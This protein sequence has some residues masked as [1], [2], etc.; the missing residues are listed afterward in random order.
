P[1]SVF[2]PASPSWAALSDLASSV[3]SHPHRRSGRRLSGVETVVLRQL[4]FAVVQPEKN[5]KPIRL[6]NFARLTWTRQTGTRNGLQTRAFAILATE[7]RA[8]SDASPNAR[9]TYPYKN[10]TTAMLTTVHRWTCLN[11]T[12]GQG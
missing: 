11:G 5:E 6:I 4:K 10:S 12:I 1:E 3:Y 9:R 8:A 7:C 2:T